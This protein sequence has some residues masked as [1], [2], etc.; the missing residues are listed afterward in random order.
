[1]ATYGSRT[2]ARW[3]IPDQEPV[4]ALRSNCAHPPLGIGVRLRRRPVARSVTLQP[5]RAV[6][7]ASKPAIT[8]TKARSAS[9]EADVVGDVDTDDPLICEGKIFDGRSPGKSYFAKGL[10]RVGPIRIGDRKLPQAGPQNE[11]TPGVPGTFSE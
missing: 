10:N 9:G 2:I 8:H 3:V 11:K 4:Q 5:L 7:A 1:M 6:N